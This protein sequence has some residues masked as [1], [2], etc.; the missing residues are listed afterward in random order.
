SLTEAR[1]LYELAHRQ[2]PTATEVRRALGLDAG[3]LSRILR[4]FQKRGWIARKPAGGDARR[5][6]ISLSRPGRTAFALLN[7][8][9]DEEIRRM[10]LAVPAGE[11]ARLLGAMQA[12]ET[13]LAPGTPE[14]APYLIRTHRPGDM[15]WVVF[16][17]GVLYSE[18][19][20]YDE[21][22]EALVAEIV[23]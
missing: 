15:G 22:F 13:V 3:Y 23:A 10:L 1:V 20:G 4:R 19:Y 8:R 5:R 12:I 18:E 17:H 14:Q 6:Q 2:D 16:R 11:R 9:S 7:A 21:R